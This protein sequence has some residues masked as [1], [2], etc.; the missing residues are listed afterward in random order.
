[1]KRKP[2]VGTAASPQLGNDQI[3]QSLP[4]IAKRPAPLD[5]KMRCEAHLVGDNN[6]EARLLDT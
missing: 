4:H 1:M 2:A 5:D 3:R 6:L